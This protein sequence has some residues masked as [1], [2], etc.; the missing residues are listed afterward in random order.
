MGR[1]MNSLPGGAWAYGSRRRR[2]PRGTRWSVVAVATAFFLVVSS[3][4]A[5]AAVWTDQ[6][7]YAPGSVVTISGDNSNGAG[8]LPGET[9]VV[10]VSG[11]NGYE[12]SCE[13]VA[14]E[15]GA[16]SCQVT[17]WDSDLAVGE[18]T[19]T[20][21]GQTSG[22]TETGTFTDAGNL[23]YSPGSVTLNVSPGGSTSFF[24]SVTAPKNNGSFTAKLKVAGTLSNP[25]PSTWVTASPT[26][27]SFSTDSG[28]DTQSWTVTFSPPADAACGTY[29]AN[30]KASPTNTTGVGEG[31]GTAVTLNVTGCA[32]SNTAPSVAFD[33]GQP[34][35]ADEG[36]TK[37]FSFTITDPDAGDSHSFVSGY[38]DCGQSNG[39]QNT[40][41]TASITGLTGTFECKFEDGADPAQ[42]STVSVRVTD[43]KADS[44]VAT[45]P[46]TVNNVA[47]TVAQPSFG[48]AS[49]DCRN[50]VTLS[51]ISF[52]DPGVNDYPWNVNIHWGDGSTDTNYNTNSQ[53]SQ[54]NQT[55]TYNSPGTF[56]A[57]V[58]VKDKD[59]GE[60]SNM[61][62][63]AVVVNQVYAVDFLP[64]FDDSSP[65]GLIINKMKNGRVVPV[66]AT[67]FDKCTEAYVNDPMTQV[68]IKV[69]KTSGN[70]SSDS[71][72][73]YADAG[74][75]SAGT[76]AFRW[77]TD[78]T[79]P[80]G[81]FWI[82]NL[83][84]KALGLVVGNLYRIDIYVGA[85]L[86]TR[87]TWA[88]L[89]PVK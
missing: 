71:I 42:V 82:Y 65:S 3:S 21:T 22:V 37:T 66:K 81:G 56:T 41:V 18:Y 2:P 57:T 23:T 25:I 16:W 60:G 40:L 45:T 50:S 58:T 9:V 15:N 53:G 54:S 55:H 88:V 30:I 87:D 79:A 38:P 85:N 86:A 6:Q 8:Y 11:P 62:S 43:G 13:A 89:A 48:A 31:S 63:N 68:T 26:Q 1:L 78:S 77:T 24:Q 69:S 14:D 20:A 4:A 83:D 35:T 12:A 84:S 70:G 61:S 64:P 32:L 52:S 39:V 29:K 73:E 51:D 47:P 5:F 10:N 17:L 36:D 7:D 27:L 75:S 19:Y 67:I 44:N 74:Q 33:T 46:V 34:T 49:I 80:G 28:S 76:N 59:G 72:E